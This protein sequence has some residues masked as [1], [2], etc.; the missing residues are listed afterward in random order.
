MA[1]TNASFAL[2]LYNRLSAL[3]LGNWL[4]TRIICFKAPYFASIS[5][6]FESLG[7]GQC[8]VRLKKR[9][10]VTNH[11]GTIHA[12]ALCNG[13]ELAAGTLME[14]SVARNM[15]WIPKGMTVRY[16]A[17]A[18][19]DVQLSAAVPNTDWQTAQDVIVPV[20][21]RDRGGKE[22]FQADITMYV[23]PRAA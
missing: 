9:R 8:N 4:F 10:K 7:K 23:S 15:R 13:A 16:L 5:P 19:T 6:Y 11:I 22:V 1:D 17:K 12:I 18:E 2:R 14:A 21:A 3:P 20:S